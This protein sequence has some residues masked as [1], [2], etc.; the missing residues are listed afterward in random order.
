MIILTGSN[1]FIGKEVIN[2]ITRKNDFLCLLRKTADSSFLEQQ[3]IR[4][5]K[6]DLYDPEFLVRALQ[7]A[8]IVVHL[9]G[10]THSADREELERGNILLTQN[11]VRAA[12]KNEIKK[13]IFISSA[14]VTSKELGNYGLS[15]KKAEDIITKSGLNY[16]I[17][18][19]AVVYG[20]GD[21]KN[22]GKLIEAVRKAPFIPVIGSGDYRIQPILVEDLAKIIL[23]SIGIKSKKKIILVAG[24]RSISFNKIIGAICQALHKKKV[25]IHLPQFAALLAIFLYEKTVKQPKI[26]REQII[27]MTEDKTYNLREMVK[28]FKIELTDFEEGLKRTIN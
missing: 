3:K 23:K 7:D 18:R 17:L 16:I 20:K 4:Y 19:P 13:F 11:L 22:I 10:V 6:G 25:I 24:P 21:D 28:E 14:I 5:V 15:K 1:G 8:E 9:A 12:Q 26:I 2:Q 27:R